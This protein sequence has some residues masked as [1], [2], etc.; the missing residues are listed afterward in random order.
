[1]LLLLATMLTLHGSPQGDGLP[2]LQADERTALVT[3]IDDRDHQEAA[4]A[5]LLEWCSRLDP[6]GVD[7]GVIEPWTSE[8]I[9]SSLSSPDASRGEPAVLQGRL[10]QART[11][12][13]PWDGVCEWFVR[14]PGDEAVAVY[15]LGTPAVEPGERVRLVGRFYKRLKAVAR[16]GQERHYAAFVGVP[17]VGSS[18]IDG[19]FVL[20]LLVILMVIAWVVLRV[21]VGKRTPGRVPIRPL[22]EASESSLETPLPSDPE[23]ALDEMVRRRDDP[24]RKAG[25]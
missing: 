1:M 7:L 6:T 8:R 16:D 12:D 3:A 13:A 10:E 17:S 15:L 22:H 23:A 18:S 5:A 19:R 11:L 21:L 14:L 4:F 25:Q 9:V 2:A 20:T 24:G